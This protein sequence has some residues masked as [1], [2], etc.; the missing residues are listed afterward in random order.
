M[1]HSYASWQETNFIDKKNHHNHMIVVDEDHHQHRSEHY[2]ISSM[3]GTSVSPR[4]DG[5]HKRVKFDN[6]IASVLLIH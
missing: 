2:N 4:L 3:A 6:F 5:R 1:L